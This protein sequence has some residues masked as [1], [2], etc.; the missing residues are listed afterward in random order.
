[1]TE[2]PKP[3]TLEDFLRRR[4]QLGAAHRGGTCEPRRPR[5]PDHRAAGAQASREAATGPV[6]RAEHRRS[7]ASIHSAFQRTVHLKV[8]ARRRVSS[9]LKAIT[10]A[11]ARSGERPSR[12]LR[13]AF[14]SIRTFPSAV[15]LHLSARS[16]SKTVRSRSMRKTLWASCGKCLGQ[17]APPKVLG[18]GSG[19]A[20][21]SFF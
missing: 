13:S 6:A 12:D 8:L 3:F 17:T 1:M 2:R 21:P 15:G 9:K 20:P 7:P 4:R 10:T 18:G 11:S 14:A 16:S 5:P 19:G